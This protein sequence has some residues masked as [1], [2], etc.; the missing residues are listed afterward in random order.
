[1]ANEMLNRYLNSVIT[2]FNV[3]HPE[4]LNTPVLRLHRCVMISA[5]KKT[6]LITV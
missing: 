1:M 5:A 6:P 2:L 3:S 4:A